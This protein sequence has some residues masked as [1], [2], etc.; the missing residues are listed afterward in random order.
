MGFLDFL[1]STAKNIA[2]NAASDMARG[3]IHNAIDKATGT[4]GG[5]SSSAAGGGVTENTKTVA[6]G[7]LP[8]TLAELKAMPQAAL[9]DEFEVAALCVA[10]MCN[11][12]ADRDATVEML[13][14][15]RGPRPLSNYD[16]QFLAERLAGKQYK[17]FAFFNGASPANEYTPAEPL[18][19]NVFSNPYSYTNDGYANLWLRSSGA[20]SPMPISLR[21]KSSTGQWF[22]WEMTFLTD[23]REPA[24]QDPWR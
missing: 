3:A 4:V 7:R 22:I 5:T 10:A 15:L 19:I 12:T 9:T 13:N 23:I 8:R 14:F 20:D 1:F 18:A 24:S 11:F 6:I 2:T 16:V 17:T 21:K